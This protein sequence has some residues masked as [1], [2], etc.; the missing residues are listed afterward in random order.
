MFT[1]RMK[2]TCATQVE[3]EIIGGIITQCRFT[4]GCMGNT[5]GLSRM[6]I[7]QKADE[8]AQKLLGTPCQGDTSCPDQLAKAIMA[9]HD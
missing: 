8:V 2:G 1:Y 9:Y 4:K 6:I 3:L 7:G 5:G